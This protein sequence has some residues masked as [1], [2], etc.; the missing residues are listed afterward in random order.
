MSGAAPDAFKSGL[1]N[2]A[3]YPYAAAPT[4]PATTGRISLTAAP[5]LCADN[6]FASTQDG[7]KIQIAGCNGTAAQ[8]FDVQA[9]GSLRIQGK[10][11]NAAN[12]DTA[13]LTLL[14]LSTCSGAPA[15]KFLPRADGSIYNPVSGR[16]MDLGNFDTTPGRQLWLYDCNPSNAQRWTIMTLGTAPLPLPSLD[17]T[18]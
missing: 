8:N 7:N 13:N 3:A 15:Q 2:F 14:E 16:C 18:P 6:D 9:D 12:A 5:D 17:A 10:C 1:S 11:V 4:A